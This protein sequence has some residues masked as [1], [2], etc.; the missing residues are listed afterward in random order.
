[1]HTADCVICDGRGN[2]ETWSDFAPQETQI[3][4]LLAPADFMHLLLATHP[5]VSKKLSGK[6]TVTWKTGTSPSS[7]TIREIY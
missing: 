6:S 3:S 1:M 2:C 4:R 7:A 5:D